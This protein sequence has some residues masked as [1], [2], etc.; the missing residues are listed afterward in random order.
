[1]KRL[2][3]ILWIV[4]ALASFLTACQPSPPEISPQLDPL[5]VQITP[6]SRPVIPAVQACGKL[7]PNVDLRLMERFAAQAE[8][9]LLIRLGE[10]DADGGFLA[11][12]ASEE[13]AVVFHQENPAGSLTVDQIRELFTG[14]T[15]S[16]G[17]AGE[18][19]SPVSVWALYPGD[20]A[21]QAFEAQLLAGVPL[22]SSADLAPDPEALREAVAADPAAIGL[23][24]S[25]WVAE[26]L[27]STLVGIRLPVL[28]ASSQPLD[29]PA[30]EL[31][32]CLQGETGQAILSAIYP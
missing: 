27:K 6:A 5:L 14:Q 19:A 2:S 13:I 16:W 15:T 24:P 3:L 26:G 22:V 8:P 18:G 30:A 23:L 9:G 20:E 29:G 31:A 21:Q 28:I 32:A 7:L 17:E 12:I 1:M 10:P 25:A 4:V 11:Q